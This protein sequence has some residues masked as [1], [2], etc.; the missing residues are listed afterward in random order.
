MGQ[1]VTRLLNEIRPAGDHIV[2]WDGTD[3][4][5][6]RVAT[7]VYF[8]RLNAADMVETRKMLLLK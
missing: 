4:A 1:K 7:G 5:N 6:H 3:D 8:Y 2:R